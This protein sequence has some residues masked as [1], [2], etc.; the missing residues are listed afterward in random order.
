[1]YVALPKDDLGFVLGKQ[2]LR[3][4]TSV[5]AQY[6]ESLRA[7]SRAEFLSKIESTLQE[8]EETSYWLE[9]LVE[10]GVVSDSKMTELRKEASELTAILISSAKTARRGSEKRPP[11]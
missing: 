7:R 1:M 3:S 10:G 11:E 5:G 4:G 9:L 6:R 8:L 2:V